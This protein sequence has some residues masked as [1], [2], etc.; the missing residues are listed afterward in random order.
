M[1]EQGTIIT[2]AISHHRHA[3]LNKALPEQGIIIIATIAISHHRRARLNKALPEQAIAIS[4]HRQSGASTQYARWLKLAARGALASSSH[5][6]ARN[7][8]RV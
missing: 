5:R 3:R 1:P 7:S 2:I 8:Y 4:H 6:Q